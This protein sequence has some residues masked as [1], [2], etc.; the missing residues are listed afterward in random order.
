M[1]EVNLEDFKDIHVGPPAGILEK[2]EY[3]VNCEAGSLGD[4]IAATAIF[5]NGRTGSVTLTNEE[6][7]RN[8]SAIFNGL[9]EV[10]FV[11]AVT[12]AMPLKGMGPTSRR[13]LQALEINDV[14]SPLVIPKPEDVEWARKW[15]SQWKKPVVINGT[16]GGVNSSEHPLRFYRKINHGAMQ[17]IVDKIIEHGGQPLSFGC[18][19]NT[20]LFSGAISTPDLPIA[21]LAAIYAVVK[22]YIGCDTGDYHLMLSVGGKCVTLVPDNDWHYNYA[23]HHYTFKDFSPPEERVKY[24]NFRD[25]KSLFP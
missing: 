6:K 16:I 10:K 2:K 3:H 9:C 1:N 7:I 23:V 25:Y 13:I 4:M 18:T 21:K 5:K 11:P 20:E 22:K 12:K 14:A 17:W 8:F 19:G 24:V 15:L